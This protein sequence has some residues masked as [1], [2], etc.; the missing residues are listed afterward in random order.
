MRPSP[1][2]APALVVV[3]DFFAGRTSSASASRN[4][5]FLSLATGQWIG[6]VRAVS[7]PFRA[8][9]MHGPWPSRPKQNYRD[10]KGE[11][12][13]GGAYYQQPDVAGLS[14]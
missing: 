9:G 11:R 3:R 13:L 4:L 6:P 14:G 5:F 2:A 12:A 7:R 8:K 10:G 1:V